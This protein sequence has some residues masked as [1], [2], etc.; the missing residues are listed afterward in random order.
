MSDKQDDG[1]GVRDCRLK[2]PGYRHAGKIGI[3]FVWLP[4]LDPRP[5]L[6]ES[7]TTSTAGLSRRSSTLALYASPR[8]AIRLPFSVSSD[9][10]MQADEKFRLGIVHEGARQRSSGRVRAPAPRGTTDRR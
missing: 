9:R 10:S 8:A 4:G 6:S 7:R 5:G 2:T 3:R 1:L